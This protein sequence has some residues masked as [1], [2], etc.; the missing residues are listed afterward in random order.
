MDHS[1]D[2]LIVGSTM[3]SPVV[4]TLNN[5][6][7]GLHAVTISIPS[8]KSSLN[9][10]SF[11]LAN[12]MSTTIYLTAVDGSSSVDDVELLATVDGAAAGEG[13]ETNEVLTLPTDIRAADTP[14]GMLDRIPDV[15][16]TTFSVGLSVPLT[17]SGER[18][19]LNV[20]GQSAATGTVEFIGTDG[21]EED[22]LPVTRRVRRSRLSG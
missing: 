19:M 4:V 3:P 18:V 15:N 5:A 8:G 17:G 1:D 14:D 6:G 13:Y 20:T 22:E 12:G 11:E 2:V 16:P 21:E 7:P 10:Y 9:T